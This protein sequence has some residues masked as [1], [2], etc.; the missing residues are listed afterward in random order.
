[1]ANVERFEAAGG[2]HIYQIRLEAFSNFFVY[3]YLLLNGDTP[4]LID[5]GS[6]MESSQKDLQA[7][8]ASI[9]D[10]FGESI[11]IEDIRRILI[12]HGHIDHHGGL[13]YVRDLTGAQVGIH[14]LDRRILTA[15]EE[16]VVVATRNLHVYL[17]RA[18]VSERTIHNLLDMYGFAKRVLRSEKVDFLLDENTEL[19]GMRFFHVPGHCPGQVCIQIDDV[20]LTADHVLSRI[21]PHQAPESITH[22]TG[23]GH[24]L[25]SLDKIKKVTGI[26]LAM[27]G[28]EDPIHDL[29]TRID[30]IK[31]DHEA[32]LDRV[33]DVIR[34]GGSALCISDISKAMYPDMSGY[35]VLLALEEVGAH[36]E[37]LYERG[38][39]AVENLHEL[40]HG[41]NPALRYRVL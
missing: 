20:M 14:A 18:G 35:H 38:A 26:R 28:H 6:S 22:Y 9:R 32:K 4:T 31:A 16:R 10:D 24:Y 29:Y 25:E 13:N 33:C 8:F 34:G 1:M 3:A 17:E 30:A 21:T 39:L 11:K 27:G 15:Y 41:E 36:V 5:C 2:L 37:Y 7:G 23:L 40:E 19:D 12:T